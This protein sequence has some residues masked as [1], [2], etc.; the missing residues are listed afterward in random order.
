MVNFELKNFFFR[1]VL[2]V[3]N[4][5]DADF[6]THALNY[7]STMKKALTLSHHFSFCSV[8]TFL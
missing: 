6:M 8:G 4:F 1:K 2:K 7:S 3:L 5:F